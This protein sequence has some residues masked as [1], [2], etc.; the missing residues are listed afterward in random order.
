[1]SDTEYTFYMAERESTFKYAECILRSSRD[2]NTPIRSMRSASTSELPKLL[3]SPDRELV[4][5]N[6]KDADSLSVQIETERLNGVNTTNHV[7]NLIQMVLKLSKEVQERRKDNEILKSSI[8]KI[9][10][11]VPVSSVQ[12]VKS[13]L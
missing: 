1:M 8:S 12:T 2:E 13:A 3:L 11:S 9:A 10:V 7:N 6:L 5:Q 4:L